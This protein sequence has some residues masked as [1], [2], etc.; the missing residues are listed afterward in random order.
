MIW[1]YLALVWVGICVGNQTLIAQTEKTEKAAEESDDRI[2]FMTGAPDLRKIRER[3]RDWDQ[4]VLGFRREH[5]FS[6]IVGPTRG[7]WKVK[8]FNNQVNKSHDDSGWFSKVNYSYHEQLYEGFGYYLGSSAGYWQTTKRSNSVSVQS[9]TML[10]GV[11][12]GFSLNITPGFRMISGIEYYLERWNSLAEDDD[13][14]EDSR[15][16]VTARAFDWL[17]GFDIFFRLKWG[18]RFEAHRRRVE[19]VRP[20]APSGKPV[21]IMISREDEI[22]ALGLVY[23]LM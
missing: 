2:W 15:V 7:T 12:A 16:S 18:I 1:R 5:N 11:L 22:L 13:V 9:A 8:H 6:F 4:S 10:P 14:A 21:D 17:I 23:H 3:I 19:Y 20:D